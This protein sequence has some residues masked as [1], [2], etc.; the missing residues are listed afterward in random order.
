[1]HRISYNI[2][3][4]FKIENKIK[5]IIL[6]A[7][8]TMVKS[9]NM[10]E[11]KLVFESLCYLLYSEVSSSYVRESLVNLEG[12]IKGEIKIDTFHPETFDEDSITREIC[13][14]YRKKSPFGRYFDKL[15]NTCRNMIK[16]APQNEKDM[17]KNKNTFYYPEILDYLMTYYFPLLP[18]WTGII[19]C[20]INDATTDSNAMIEN[21]FRIVKYSIFKSETNIKAG[22]F[23]R[24]IFTH[25]DDRLA[26]FKFA[27]Q[28]LA[29]KVFKSKKR[30]YEVINEE[31]C[32]E[33]WGKRKKLRRSYIKP[34]PS[35]KI[36]KVFDSF[37]VDLFK[38]PNKKKR[39]SSSISNSG[40]K[41]T[42]ID[43]S[44]ET[45]VALPL[46]DVEIITDLD[47]LAVG[48]IDFVLPPFKPL[49][50]LGKKINNYYM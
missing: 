4:K 17:N 7:I 47:V 19:L 3:K 8:G 32:K 39:A 38:A 42:K 44:L 35:Q 50:I 15:F 25:I 45:P 41:K 49:S 21:W 23:I 40:I 11:I 27:F 20:Q 10:E 28:P 30:Q 6:H 22:D 26:T 18:F 29:H 13:E 48:N 33:E 2:D 5:K 9:N 43:E 37:R 34:V 16:L 24:T 1:M 14:T 36:E 46:D 31:E 12:L